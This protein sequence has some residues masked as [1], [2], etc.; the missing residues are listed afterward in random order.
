MIGGKKIKYEDTIVS[1]MIFVWT[2]VVTGGL[3][4]IE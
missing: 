2:R 3:E 4:K 1:K